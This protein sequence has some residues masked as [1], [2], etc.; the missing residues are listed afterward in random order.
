M[1]S[2]QSDASDRSKQRQRALQRWENEGGAG[3]GSL[4]ADAQPG[5]MH[6][7]PLTDAEL[8]QLQIRVIALE[9]LVIA[10]LSQAPDRQLDLARAMAIHIS[11]RPGFTAHRLTIH[12]AA[13]MI[14][15]V[16]RAGYFRAPG[17]TVNATTTID[18]SFPDVRP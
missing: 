17:D 18:R 5:E 9:N 14:S 2:R 15:L 13:Q 1:P 16:E 11:P 10:L 3:P 7:V 12:A 8:V 4:A 6:C